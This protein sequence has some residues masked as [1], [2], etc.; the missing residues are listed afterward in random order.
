MRTLIFLLLI[1][2]FAVACTKETDPVFPV[3]GNSSTTGNNNP[4]QPRL[5]SISFFINNNPM[6]VTGIDYNRSNST[7]NF[8][9]W[10]SLQRVDAY[11][12]WFYGTSGFNYQFSDSMT[13]STRPDTLSAWTTIR[14]TNWGDIRFDCCM[15]PWKDSPV[16]GLDTAIFAMNK[17]SLTITGNFYLPF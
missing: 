4:P 9:A 15:A 6:R 12:F 17:Q 8:S 10:N 1:G 16:S 3:N 14:A 11:C 7:V 13:Y 2:I 5:A